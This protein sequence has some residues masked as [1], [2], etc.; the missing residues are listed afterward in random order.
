MRPRGHRARPRALRTAVSYR[1]T[2]IEYIIVPYMYIQSIQ[3][4]MDQA[5]PLASGSSRRVIM[6][7][8]IQSDC[9]YGTTIHS[10]HVYTIQPQTFAIRGSARPIRSDPP[11]RAALWLAALEVPIGRYCTRL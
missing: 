1:I 9:T 4:L 3:R 2:F 8:D 10:I 11:R 5:R 6:M 7:H